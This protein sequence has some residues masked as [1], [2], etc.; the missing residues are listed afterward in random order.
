MDEVSLYERV[1]VSFNLITTLPVE[2]P[3]RLPHLQHLNIS[4][5]RIKELPESIALFFH[6]EELNVSYNLLSSLPR[7]ITNM[8]KLS[9]LDISHNQFQRL[10]D[11]IGA[12]PGLKKLNASHNQLSLLP[13]SLGASPSLYV[14]LVDGNKF[15]STIYEAGSDA[16]LA[17]LREA[18]PAPSVAPPPPPAVFSRQNAPARGQFAQ[19]QAQTVET[20][21]RTRTPLLPPAGASRLEPEQLRDALA[22]LLFG[23][24]LG[25]A[26]GLATDGLSGDQCRF[27]YSADYTLAD[28]VR[29]E[30]R[31]RYR[32]GD[33]TS[34]TDLMVS[35]RDRASESESAGG[36]RL[37]LTTWLHDQ[38]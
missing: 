31:V 15:L 28:T 35:G 23:A 5:N 30:R 13:T 19:L 9:V 21:R 36:P 6:L 12:I 3:L 16:V 7:N 1:N 8:R 26:L 4:H 11:D 34:N 14:L 10:P 20:G 24:A 25:D 37:L 29:D 27:H 22:G 33:W 32:D 17:Q 18:A 38:T 2:L